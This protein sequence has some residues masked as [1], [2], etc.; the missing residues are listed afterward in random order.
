MALLAWLGGLATYH[1]LANLY[2][3]VGATLP[4]LVVAG[5]LQFMLGKAFNRGRGTVPA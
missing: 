4:A 2:P 5:V 3:N 1:L